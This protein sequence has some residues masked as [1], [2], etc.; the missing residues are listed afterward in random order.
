VRSADRWSWS[1]ANFWAERLATRCGSPTPSGYS[2]ALTR[3]AGTSKGFSIKIGECFA[4]EFLV[5]RRSTGQ[6]ADFGHTLFS[7]HARETP[8]DR[9]SQMIFS[10]FSILASKYALAAVGLQIHFISVCPGHGRKSN[11][12]ETL[13]SFVS[14]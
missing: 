11:S 5:C 9:R 3:R 4:N 1:G 2:R 12:I 14:R 7:R 13:P 8:R 10:H 6:L